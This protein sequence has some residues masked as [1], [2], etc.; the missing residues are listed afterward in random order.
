M[1][2]G[3]IGK[4]ILNCK[5]FFM[6]RYNAVSMLL[7]LLSGFSVVLFAESSAIFVG[8][9]SLPGTKMALSGSVSMENGQF[10][11]A[12][13]DSSTA[14]SRKDNYLIYNLYSS[15]NKPVWVYMSHLRLHLDAY[16]QERLRVVISPELFIY[17]NTFPASVV[18][19]GGNN[20]MR[21]PF[22][23]YEQATIAEGMA[24]YS[25]GDITSPF[26]QITTGTF[27]Y[28]YDADARNLGEYMFRSGCYP[29][30]LVT[31]FDRAYSQITGFMI[32]FSPIKNLKADILLTCETQIQPLYDWSLSYLI[33]YS[34][35]SLFDIGVGVSFQRL[36]PSE[37]SVTSPVDGA[38]Q[39]ITKDND[40]LYY[41]F[42]GTKL[43]ARA[44]FDTKSLLPKN[45]SQFWGKE[46]GKI[47]GEAILLGVE[48]KE[49]Y[50]YVNHELT[51]DTA[52]NYYGKLF[53]RIPIMFGINVPAFRLL[54][55]LS[56]QGEWYGTRYS[57][58]Y[59]A[60]KLDKIIPVPEKTRY[61]DFT[62][63]NWKWSVYAKKILAGRI[64]LVCQ[65]ANDHTHQEIYDQLY[66][67]YQNFNQT[68]TSNSDW[69]WWLKLQF[70]F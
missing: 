22:R 43:M 37:N 5:G 67:V 62:K 65:I 44:S 60:T 6:K 51:L 63:D 54:D 19:D 40:T 48:N 26:L 2:Q 25:F 9:Y 12:H 35:P 8:L 13:Y 31:S 36:I 18:T 53:E 57:E 32:G 4:M 46:D 59:Y 29:G 30:Y 45:M 24:C 28:K 20:I 42:K 17:G 23:L 56:V 11:R 64:D 14:T 39:Y 49:P 10:V 33:G 70:N 47:F 38:N 50:K 21:Y 66:S 41:S 16:V 3:H 34:K 1:L 52:K 15:M 27:P 61:I 58:A 69:G 68:F 7:I 55:V